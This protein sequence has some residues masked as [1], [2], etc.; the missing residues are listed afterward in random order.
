MTMISF[1]AHAPTEADFWA[2]W[3]QAG[4]CKAPY[5]WTPA[6]SEIQITDQTRDGWVPMKDGE[7]VPGWHANIR[8]YGSLA[9]QF[10]AGLPQTDANGV[11]LP[12]FERTHAAAVF[13]LILTPANEETNFPAAYCSPH[14]E[15]RT[16]DSNK[17]NNTERR[18]LT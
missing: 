13:G 5:E 4:I 18:Q 14:V 2:D 12:L 9:E 17:L 1:A 7:P 8:V 10:I 16:S 3:I 11:L 6:Y 15:C